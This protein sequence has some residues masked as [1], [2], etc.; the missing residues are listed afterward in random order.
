LTDRCLP[1]LHI[2][3]ATC[4]I[5]F[6]FPT[7][8]RIFG[9]RMLSMLDN[10]Q[11]RFDKDTSLEQECSKAKSVLLMSEK[12][13]VHAVGILRYLERT[14]A[15]IPPELFD[16]TAGILSAK[17][18]MKHGRPLCQHLKAFGVC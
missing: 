8:Q 3:D 15:A 4:V 10:F 16:F 6:G 1:S 14:E 11:N 12:N 9:M 18:E 13:A 7:S 5:H 2:S 17:E